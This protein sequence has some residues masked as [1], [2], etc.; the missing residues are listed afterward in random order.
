MAN[1]LKN[2]NA[3]G[4]AVLV[5]AIVI[6]I[7]ICVTAGFIAYQFKPATEPLST[8]TPTP[9]PTNTVTT[10]PTSSPS[11]TPTET[12]ATGGTIQFKV[13]DSNGNPISNAIVASTQ[14]PTAID[15]LFDLTSSSGFVTFRN[16]QTGGYTFSFSA[17][18]YQTIDQTVTFRGTPLSLV[19]T[20][21]TSNSATAS[22]E[23][24]SIQGVNYDKANKIIMVYAQSSSAT[25]TSA[26]SGMIVKDSS[27]NT[28]SNIGI[29]TITPL[30][31]GNRLS[32][33]TLYT[34]TSTNISTG[35]GTGAYT[36]TLLTQAGGSF[37]S[38]AF[39]AS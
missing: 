2:S 31:S 34:I 32:T 24:I 9:L 37:V 6:V 30:S 16:M 14:T 13:I 5:T 17:V 22:Q 38:P 4:K 29:N 23:K 28:V 15:P 7:V 33:G 1:L 20:L 35:L 19:I 3:I 10:L 26:I 18:G 11:P 25:D 12:S 21:G 8:L 39:T 36:V 27:G